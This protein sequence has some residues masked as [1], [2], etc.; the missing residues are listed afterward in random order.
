MMQVTTLKY[1]GRISEGALPCETQQMNPH[2][3]SQSQIQILLECC[4]RLGGTSLHSA[5]LFCTPQSQLRTS[6]LHGD[7]KSGQLG[8]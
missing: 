3:H 6:P 7:H 8:G 4:T 2:S 1:E 5:L